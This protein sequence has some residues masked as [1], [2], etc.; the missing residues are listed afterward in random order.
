[1]NLKFVLTIS[2][3]CV[4]CYSCNTYRMAPLRGNTCEEEV[5][6]APATKAVLT[7]ELFAQIALGKTENVSH[8]LEKGASP[9]SVD[10]EGNTALLLATQENRVAIA[11]LLINAGADVNG[12]NSEGKTPLM[13]VVL[14]GNKAIPK[15]LSNGM[16]VSIEPKTNMQNYLADLLIS[17]EAE[18]EAVDNNGNSVLSIAALVG[19]IDAVSYLIKKGADVNKK[20]RFG[21][22]PLMV[23]CKMG[24]YPIAEELI[25]AKADINEVDEEGQ[26]A[27]MYAAQKENPDLVGLLLASGAM[28]DKK[29]QYGATAH[30]IADAI[31]NY[32]VLRILKGFVAMDGSE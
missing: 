9:N 19:N 22:S 17:K 12:K 30:T 20:N 29:D 10:A 11:K 31:G 6:K 32:K 15:T 4:V 23:A 16:V 5:C 8:L 13:Q 21:V 18:I 14:N 2:A 24:H 7:S 25:M 28:A 3:F 27:L 1:M 26:T